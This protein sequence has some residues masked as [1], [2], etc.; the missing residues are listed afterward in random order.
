MS[1]VKRSPSDRRRKVRRALAEAVQTTAEIQGTAR[2]RQKTRA[3]GN[4]NDAAVKTTDLE[5]L[6]GDLR[7]DK[8]ALYATGLIP[9][10]TPYRGRVKP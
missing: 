4:A 9:E 2:A 5:H 3:A 10:G 1:S 6:Y 7:E 8:R